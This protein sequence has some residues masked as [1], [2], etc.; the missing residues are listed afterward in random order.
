VFVVHPE[1]PNELPAA[2]D[3]LRFHRIVYVTRAIPSQ[4][5]PALERRLRAGAR[6]AADPSD[7]Y[8]SSF[9]PS[10]VLSERG[11]SRRCNHAF[12]TEPLDDALLPDFQE[13]LARPGWRLR[14]DECRL[15]LDLR[16][17]ARRWEDAKEDARERSFATDLL[18]DDADCRATVSRWGR[19]VTNRRVGLALSGGGASSY[20]MV[21]LIRALRSGTHD[22]PI[23][24]VSAISGGALVAAYFCREGLAGLD[25]CVARGRSYQLVVF[26]AIFDSRA[27][28][29]MID[30]DLGGARLEELDVRFVPLTTAL[31]REGP[32]AAHAVVRGTLGEAVRASGGAPAA[33]APT[34]KGGIRYTDGAIATPIPARILK[35][36]GADLVLACNCVPGPERR[37][38]FGGSFL[39]ELV[40][41]Y[42]PAGRLIDLWVS[43]A[44]LLQRISREVADDAHVFMEA[45]AQPMP[46]VESFSFTRAAEIAAESAGDPRV[47]ADTVRCRERWREFARIRDA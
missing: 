43:A 10:V 37:N 47:R 12:E 17:L 18:G 2:F 44:F 20:R 39:A 1:Q 40:Y 41:R 35:D 4:I 30:W 6:N 32:P 19:A 27:I 31:P 23:D 7:A 42:T 14:R 3:D 8:F 5:P 45:S 34:E 22:V 21:P 15:R 28:E 25:R 24:V 16:R 33:F 26:A 46:L 9:I 13:P 29:T 11:R 38:P 36:Y